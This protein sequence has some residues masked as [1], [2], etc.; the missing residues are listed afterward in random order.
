MT[1]NKKTWLGKKQL[2]IIVT[3]SVLAFLI[4]AYAI[5]AAV[6]N[7]T[8]SN[9][10]DEVAQAPEILD[11]E[12]LYGNN[13]IAYPMFYESAIKK[14]VVNSHKGAYSME[15]T[16]ISNP[17]VFYYEDVNGE[18]QIYYPEICAAEPG[19]EYTDLYAIEQ[20]D[21][22]DMYK[23]SYLASALGVMYFKNRIPLK[24]DAADTAAR[25]EEL[26]VYGLS[27]DERQGIEVTF[28]NSEGKEQTYV[29]FIGDKLI[30]GVGYY[31]MI[32][33]RDYVYTGTNN[34]FDYALGGFEGFLHTRLVAEGLEEDGIY[35]P[36]LASDY[37]QWVN[38]VYSNTRDDEDGIFDSVIAASTVV[39]RGTLDAPIYINDELSD[40]TPDGYLLGTS[41]L[42][43][44][45]LAELAKHS[46]FSRVVSALTGKA[47]GAY[48]DKIVASVIYDTLEIDF[49]EEQT[50]TYTYHVTA[51]ESILT[52]NGEYT[53]D[54][55][56]AAS[57]EARTMVK[58]TYDLYLGTEKQNEAARHAIID[59]SDVTVPA[60]ALTA[61]SSAGIGAA[62]ITFDVTYDKETAT[63]KTYTYV[64][65]E[66]ALICEMSGTNTGAMLN[67]VTGTS[68]VTYR[69]YYM[70]DGVRIGNE[71]S[72]TVDLSSITSGDE[73]RIKEALVGKTS[74]ATG[75][76]KVLEDV[77]YCQVMMNFD[78]YT[79]ES[80]EYYVTEELVTS[81]EFV[82]ADDRDPFYGE[83]L[84]KNTLPVGHKNYG[85]ALNSTTC[86]TVV[87]LLGG[88]SAETSQYSEGLLGSQT[89]AVGITPENMKEFGLYAYTV[90]FELPR[91][92]QIETPDEDADADAKD[93]YVPLYELGF[94][95]YISE[96]NEDGTRYVGSDMYDIIVKIDGTLFDYLDNSFADYWAR[97][98]LVMVNYSDI[99]SMTVDLY[100]DDLYGSYGLQM[101]HEDAWIYN[102]ELKF[103]QPEEGGQAYDFLT[104]KVSKLGDCTETAFSRYLESEGY[105]Q[106]S[107][108]AIYNYA[109]GITDGTLTYGYDTLGTANFK[110]FL[111]IMFSTYF[112][113][114]L[115]AE[116][117]KLAN[118][119]NLLMKISFTVTD[120]S[121]YPYVYSFYRIDDRRVM[122]SITQVGGSGDTVMRADD[123]YISTFAFKKI[124]RNF[125]DLLNGVS[126]DPDVG[127]DDKYYSAG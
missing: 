73:L 5:I 117:K 112:G 12:S 89:V 46:E 42:L 55:A 87:K 101:E 36:F 22:M 123:F 105:S 74:G 104:V 37:K 115:T 99:D 94:T 44:F 107:L 43:S 110:D 103:T 6:M 52:A 93:E 16:D 31:F 10:D 126:I 95:L 64:I 11:C 98:G 56:F 63:S 28:L 84:Y 4:I 75:G 66:I 58:V 20:S 3:A 80:L 81:F 57:G 41:K 47:L 62:D 69:Y 70:V 48:P 113:D 67:T 109:A 106:M 116:E 102:N 71:Y 118:E 15:R 120:S 76:L 35:E 85:Y 97:R 119:D 39:G 7:A 122:V 127:Y 27:S 111:M 124:V 40:D 30:S 88:I 65:S 14:I 13:P 19:F 25:A 9:P 59:L 83:S 53:A 121:P 45:D 24:T 90:Y 23:I 100:M 68:A 2:A 82:N 26:D 92:I 32:Q 96:K 50:A 34:R 72:R 86:E 54:E 125:I 77:I 60:E 78:T 1:I 17:F 79:L 21:G 51:I 91:S 29:I 61:L 8:A 33:G 18:T 108:A 49:G 38:R 114:T